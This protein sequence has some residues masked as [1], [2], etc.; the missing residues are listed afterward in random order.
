MGSSESANP[1]QLSV[2]YVTVAC[3]TTAPVITQNPQ[4][5]TAIE[6]STVLLSAGVSNAC[7]TTYQWQKN[8]V[9]IN[10]PAA[11]AGPTYSISP[12]VPGDSGAYR[13]VV[14]KTSGGAQG[15]SGAATVT[16]TNDTVRPVVLR[17]INTNNTSL[18]VTFSK[19]MGA[20]AGVAGN[21]TQ[22]GVAASAAVLAADGRS[23]TLTTAARTFP[24]A[25]SLSIAGV[26]DNRAV[27]NLINPNPT[28][29]P[30]TTVNVISAWGGAWQYN[31]NNQDA[32]PTWKSVPTGSL[33]ASWLTGNELFGIETSAGIVALF[34]TPIGTALLPNTNTPPDLVTYYFRK[35]ITLPA[36]PAGTTYAINHFIDDGAV[37]Y[38]DGVEIGRLNMPAAPAAVAYA[39]KA[40]TA[41]EAAFGSLAFSASASA[42][43]LAVEVHQGGATTSSDMLFGAQIVAIRTASPALTISHVG[44]NAVVR[45]SADTKWQL[46]NSTTT[47]TGPYGAVAIPAANPLGFFST[48]ATGTNNYFRL[49]YIGP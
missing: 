22:N 39:T 46:E 32:S 37:F 3:P 34:P 7:N 36:L 43:V 27:P 29:V 44:A 4:S 38:L 5:V 16:I 23:V 20:S 11:T 49:H 48:P 31:T 18:V 28:V 47:V 24:T 21:Y 8:G 17:V 14:T 10:T 33:D 25:Y 1:P 12:A 40:T 45:W 26:S 19:V 41:G 2:V 30:I 6:G 35:D 15:I 42:H 9:N 13:L